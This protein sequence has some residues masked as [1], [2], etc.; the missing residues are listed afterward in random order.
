NGSFA[1]RAPGSVVD[2]ERARLAKAYERRTKF[3]E[4][5]EALQGKS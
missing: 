2:K 4:Q 5:L 1:D 3:A